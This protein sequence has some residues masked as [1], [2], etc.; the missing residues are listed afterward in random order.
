MREEEIE[1][2]CR[3]WYGENWDS[4]EEQPGA[5]VKNVWRRFA[6]G[7]VSAIRRV[8]DERRMTECTC[9]WETGECQSPLGCK[10]VAEISDTRKQILGK[11][12]A[13]VA[14]YEHGE[15]RGSHA[16]DKRDK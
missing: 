4:P 13:R 10:A 15:E 2:V 16:P 12:R 6:R 3:Y 1:A 5:S 8:E 9:D 7:A 11:S 14:I